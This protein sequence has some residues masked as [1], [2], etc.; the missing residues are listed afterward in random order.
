MIHLLLVSAVTGACVL[1]GEMQKAV[2]VQEKTL[3]L[4][5]LIMKVLMSVV[6]VGV[7]ATNKSNI[8]RKETNQST[9]TYVYQ[10]YTRLN[11]IFSYRPIS[12]Y[13][14]D[15]INNNNNNNIY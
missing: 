9:D 2:L 1:F 14:N 10:H 5:Q 13:K 8:W 6:S 11:K 12:L 4:A 15:I 3:L 7:R